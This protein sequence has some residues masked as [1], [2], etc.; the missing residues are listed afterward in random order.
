[1]TIVSTRQQGHSLTFDLGHSYQATCNS[2]KNIVGYLNQIFND[3]GKRSLF[4]QSL[5]QGEQGCS[6]DSKDEWFE[7]YHRSLKIRP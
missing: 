3:M 7:F 6:V 2:S 1:M 4:K 5:S